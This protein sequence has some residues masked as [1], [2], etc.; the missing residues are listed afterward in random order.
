[1]LE[2]IA[3]KSEILGAARA[4]VAAPD[5]MLSVMTWTQGSSSRGNT[6]AC[7]RPCTE[8][9]SC[10]SDWGRGGGT[11]VVDGGGGEG[12]DVGLGV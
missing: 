5:D 6:A 3:C 1:M 7:S 12:V 9:Y 10:A 4:W 11:E 8:C 2:K